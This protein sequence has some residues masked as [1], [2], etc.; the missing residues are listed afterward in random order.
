MTK[1]SKLTALFTGAVMAMLMTTTPAAASGETV[2]H[3]GPVWRT[4]ITTN[5]D[6]GIPLCGMQ[7]NG[8][9]SALI[10]KY[11]TSGKMFMHIFKNGWSIPNGTKIA[12]YIAFD[13][14]GQFPTVGAGYTKQGNSLVEFFVKEDTE[15]DFLNLFKQAKKMIIG[16]DEG[17]Q[18]P[19]TVDMTGSAEAATVFASCSAQIDK[20]AAQQP[21]GKPNNQQPFNAPKSDAVK[22]DDGGI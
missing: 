9:G 12:G 6:T 15:I 8:N 18:P 16:F 21:F 11:T 19:L 3:Q 10:L 20:L 22:R 1:R 14:S 2:L 4:Y 5:T 13:N 7:V 17:T